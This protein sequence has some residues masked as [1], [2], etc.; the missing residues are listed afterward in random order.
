MRL[1]WLDGSVHTVIFGHSF[2]G[3]LAFE[4]TRRIE[5]EAL[6]M[7]LGSKVLGG[8]DIVSHLVVSAVPA[9][10]I[11]QVLYADIDNCNHCSEDKLRWMMKGGEGIATIYSRSY[12]K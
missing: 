3:L 2:G 7:G 9:P 5:R 12:F 11:M 10:H 1:G 4:L 6:L 8:G